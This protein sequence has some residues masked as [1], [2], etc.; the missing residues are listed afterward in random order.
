MY[1]DLRYQSRQPAGNHCLDTFKLITFTTMAH[2]G[3]WLAKSPSFRCLSTS[4]RCLK[5]LIIESQRASH[6]PGNEKHSPT[7]ICSSAISSHSCSNTSPSSPRRNFS[8]SK[9]VQSISAI[10]SFQFLHGYP[11]SIWQFRNRY[12]RTARSSKAKQN[13]S[14]T[15]AE[16]KGRNFVGADTAL[17]P[18]HL[19]PAF[20]HLAILIDDPNVNFDP[21]WHSRHPH[22]LVLAPGISRLHCMFEKL[23]HSFSLHL[24]RRSEVRNET[25]LLDCPCICGGQDLDGEAER[26]GSHDR[27]CT[28]LSAGCIAKC[29]V[30]GLALS[31]ER[32]GVEWY[33]C[34]GQ[35]EALPRQAS[36]CCRHCC[37]RSRSRT[38]YS[39]S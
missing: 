14:S 30:E 24:L 32:N 7:T 1:H 2:Q 3:W 38:I 28:V 15:N 9:L 17:D 19:L 29:F 39:C 20:Q 31:G 37:L 23:P 25:S 4:D 34:E 36:P 13:S 21:E 16:R 33:H 10:I 5:Q 26:A 35:T 27:G 6:H 22:R 18:G 8:S 11:F 12:G